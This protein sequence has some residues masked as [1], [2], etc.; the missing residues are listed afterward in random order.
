[1]KNNEPVCAFDI[2]GI[3]IRTAETG[4]GVT[5]LKTNAYIHTY[6]KE[7]MHSQKWTKKHRVFILFNAAI[8]FKSV[9]IQKKIQKLEKLSII[10]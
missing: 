1:M 9:V 4:K 6:V 3:L 10:Y 5:S 8:I 2:H 7:R